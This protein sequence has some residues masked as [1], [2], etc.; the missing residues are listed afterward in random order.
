MTNLKLLYKTSEIISYHIS[1]D[2]YI[3]PN[4]IFKQS[5][6]VFKNKRMNLEAN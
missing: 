3:L 4:W 5:E 2:T 6:N 1:V